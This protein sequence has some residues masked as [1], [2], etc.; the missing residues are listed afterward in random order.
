MMTNDM[1]NNAMMNNDMMNN[2]MMN[3]DM[4][5]NDR[6]CRIMVRLFMAQIQ[7]HLVVSIVFSIERNLES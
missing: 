2:D 6:M 3:N 5:N 1:M 4:R 7:C